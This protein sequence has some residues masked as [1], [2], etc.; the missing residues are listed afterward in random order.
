MKAI[1]K[2]TFARLMKD[3]EG[4]TLVEY[5]VALLVVI[6]VGTAA[7]GTLA[8]NTEAN[9]NAASDALTD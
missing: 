9:I 2:K 6:G 7:M 5:A 8:D 3:E 1:L 4:V